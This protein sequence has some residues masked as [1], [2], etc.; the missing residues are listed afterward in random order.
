[1]NALRFYFLKLYNN[2]LLND[3]EK[4]FHH[5]Q[6]CIIGQ[7]DHIKISSP[8]EALVSIRHKEK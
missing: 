7:F 5:V 8:N 4:C 2:K 6:E 1:M 3:S